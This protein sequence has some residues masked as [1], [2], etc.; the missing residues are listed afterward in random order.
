MRWIFFSLI[1]INLGFFLWHA[2]SPDESKQANAAQI[3]P[4]SE[5]VASIA[6]LHEVAGQAEPYDLSELVRA[7]EPGPAQ[8]E[9]VEGVTE[10]PASEVTQLCDALGPFIDR[11]QGA[12]LAE[13][14]ESLGVETNLATEYVQ[15]MGGYWAYIEPQ[16][17]LQAAL[18]MSGELKQQ[19]ID[20]YL[21]SEGDLN[22]G[23]S[24]GI[25][26]LAADAE[27]LRQRL[28]DAGITVVVEEKP[29]VHEEFWVLLP[30]QEFA[31]IDLEKLQQLSEFTSQN[32]TI[33]KVCKPVASTL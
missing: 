27:P 20:A 8:S 11:E 16:A 25:Y 22:N 18:I 1:A 26:S 2:L 12:R 30:S 32:Q 19:G 14:F 24:L 10:E 17:S 9:S 29:A 28:Q 4:G 3:V 33:K 6:L 15:L 23:L 13:R 31:S 21:I 7:I 5:N